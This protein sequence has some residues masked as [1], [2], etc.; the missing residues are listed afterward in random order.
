MN[1]Y[2]I[3]IIT[4]ITFF[5]GYH[6]FH[7][8]KSQTVV[9][10]VS[11]RR[12]L[13]QDQCRQLDSSETIFVSVAS[14]RDPECAS[15][16]FDCLEKAY[17]PLRVFVGVCQ[18]NYDVDLDT[19]EG[20]T[21]LQEQSG[22]GNY[23]DQIRVLS[24][25]AGDAK[26][27]M[28]ARARIEQELYHGEK[29]YLIIDSHTLFSENWDQKLITSLHLC[30]H[31]KCVLTMYPGNYSGRKE[32]SDLPATYLRFKQFHPDTGLPEME[33]P[34]CVHKS[35]RPLPSLFWGGC[36]SF[37]RGDLMIRDVP[38]DPHCDYVFQGEEISMAARLFT[39]GYDL[40]SPQEMVLFHKW[41]RQRPTFWEQFTGTSVEHQKRQ[42]REQRG[43]KRL[44]FLFG[45]EAQ[46][47]TDPIVLGEY[48]LGRMRS[49]RDYQDY[50]GLDFLLQ[51][52]QDHAKLGVTWN[53]SNEEIMVK[54]GSLSEFQNKTKNRHL[55]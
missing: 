8:I 10:S 22:S 47:Q 18:Q 3:W 32:T 1:K 12:R 31:D 49:L 41:A 25:S 45:L 36:C 13:K 28:F 37:A 17:C 14:Y 5:V 6:V 44:R 23:R 29:Y 43:Y 15:T 24:M 35:S 16:V 2:L 40:Y 42:E 21:R 11:N 27:P 7:K 39:N 54:F 38:Y 34:Q 46:D 26:G 48:G 4:G 52:V 9:K 20:Y 19:L 53:A 51:Q 33:G 55:S 50:C 30:P